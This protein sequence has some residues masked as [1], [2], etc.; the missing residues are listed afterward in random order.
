MKAKADLNRARTHEGENL[1]ETILHIRRLPL[2][3]PKIT[4]VSSVHITFFQSS[5]IQCLYRKQNCK[6]ASFM[7]LV[8]PGFVKGLHDLKPVFLKNFHTVICDKS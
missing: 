2:R 8:K 3:R 6:R 1:S 5:K 7:N 4:L